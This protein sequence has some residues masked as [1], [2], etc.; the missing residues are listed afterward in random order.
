[1]GMSSL[2]LSLSNK[3]E[4]FGRTVLE[5]LSLGVPVIAYDHGG[6]SEVMKVV[7]AEGLIS[8]GDVHRAAFLI[9]DFIRN[10]RTVNK[11]NPY[12]L[13]RMQQK[14]IELYESLVYKDINR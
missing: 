14:T 5:A 2:V 4:A 6:V 11:N 1:M 13:E 8:P 7:F 9:R 12:T 10:A 3:P